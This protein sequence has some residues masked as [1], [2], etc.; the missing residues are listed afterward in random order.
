MTASDAD[1]RTRHGS[2]VLAEVVIAQA[3]HT[4]TATGVRVEFRQDST[5]PHIDWP[6]RRRRRGGLTF[7]LK[8]FAENTPKE[9]I[10]K[11]VL[12]SDP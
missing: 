12:W 1:N 9:I 4:V 6:K 7:I 3:A 2:P 11:P 10:Q 5:R 8:I